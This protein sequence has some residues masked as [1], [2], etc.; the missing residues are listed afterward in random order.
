MGLPVLH[1]PILGLA[2]LALSACGSIE[3]RKQ[4]NALETTLT[5]YAATMRWAS[6]SHAY[7]FQDPEHPTPVPPDLEDIRVVAYD[8]TVPPMRRDD[9][10]AVQTVTIGYY[11]LDSQ[12]VRHLTDAQTWRFDT[13]HKAWY[14]VS[15]PPHFR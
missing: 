10:T 7:Q 13:E 9:D 14:L 12:R 1:L 2:L 11:R 3:Q 15:D 8:V 4:A 5:A 6:P